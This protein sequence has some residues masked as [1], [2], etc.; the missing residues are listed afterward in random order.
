LS[1]VD[2]RVDRSVA[3]ALAV[4]VG[5]CMRIYPDPEL[6]D[7]KVEWFA[8][9]DCVATTDRVVV[10]LSAGDPAAEV[11][12]VMAP[13]AD[14]SLRIADVARERYHVAATLEDGAGAMLGYYEEDVDLRDGLN[15][16]V[17][18]FFG[19]G[20]ET[21]VRGAWTFDLG[22][23]C[24]SLSATQVAFGFA[25]PGEPAFTIASEPCATGMIVQS[26]PLQGTYVVSARA[27]AG[28]GVVATAPDSAPLAFSPGQLVELG[29][30]V[31]S[32]CGA[33]CPPGF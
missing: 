9:G 33:A 23:S 3:A 24:D 8:D 19:R 25:M 5:G 27:Y 11:G 32:P 12:L 29:T 21:L 28:N 7:V 22:A 17:S 15:E 6:P 13:C 2:R 20:F 31:L 14:A 26:I 10:S 1:R 16:R 4:A 18:A 30:F